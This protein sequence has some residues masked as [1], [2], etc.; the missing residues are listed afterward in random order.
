MR[1]VIGCGVPS[2]TLVPMDPGSDGEFWSTLGEAGLDVV[3]GIDIRAARL[4][5][6]RRQS[7]VTE[8]IALRDR[9]PDRFA[10]LQDEVLARPAG[11]RIDALAARLL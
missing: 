8:T 4:S 5:A 1:Q 6:E 10:V 11:E 9:D 3:W 7:L 2:G